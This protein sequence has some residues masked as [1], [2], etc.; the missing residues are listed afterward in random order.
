MSSKSPLHDVFDFFSFPFWRLLSSPRRLYWT[1]VTFA[2]DNKISIGLL[3]NKIGKGC[4]LSTLVYSS[5][6]CKGWRVID[7][8]P[9]QKISNFK[10]YLWSREFFWGL[11][12]SGRGTK[13]DGD[14][15]LIQNANK[16]K[17]IWSDVRYN[18]YNFF[19][20][21]KNFQGLN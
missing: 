7:F 15:L 11:I 16:Y 19:I 5:K 10:S 12:I 14:I 17:I 3:V 1:N 20:F 21:Y 13:G 6:N 8:F 9:K 4:R 18:S 2:C